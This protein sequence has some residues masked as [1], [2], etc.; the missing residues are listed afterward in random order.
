MA[1]KKKILFAINCLNIGGAPTVIFHQLSLLNKNK[2][3]LHL[4]LLY[5]SKPANYLT[6][7]EN[8]IGKDNIYQLNYKRN[9]K[10]DFRAFLK[11]YKLLRKGKFDV[12]YTHLFLANFIVRLAAWFSG[13]NKIISFEHSAYSDKKK[14]QIYVDRLLSKFTDYIIVSTDEV[15]E[16]TISQQKLPKNKCMVIRNPVVIPDRK[17]VNALVIKEKLN[18]LDIDRVFVTIGRFSKVKGHEILL[19]ALSRIKAR[20][21]NSHFVLVGHGPEE[22]NLRQSIREKKLENIVSLV[23][24]PIRAR[25]YLF[26]ADCFILPSLREG[27]AMAAEEAVRAGLPVLAS[28]LPAMGDLVEDDINGITFTPGDY[29]ELSEIIENIDAGS[30]DLGPLGEGSK[31]KSRTLPSVEELIRELERL[32]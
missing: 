2:F 27:Q 18:I 12:V 7:V 32:F 3:E 10:F 21:N 15:K 24:D 31:I 1:H 28:K 23:H 4:L 29:V 13:I 9:S 5:R 6:E 8:L 22:E 16:F 25:D 19:Q 11:V 20:I 30:I 26:A 14:W 17:D